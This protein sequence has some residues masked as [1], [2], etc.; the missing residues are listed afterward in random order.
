MCVHKDISDREIIFSFI[1]CNELKVKLCEARLGVAVSTN[2]SCLL[3]LLSSFSLRSGSQ[4]TCFQF[5]GVHI[6]IRLIYV[7]VCVIAVV[8]GKLMFL[9]DIMFVY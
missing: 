7:Y 4:Q 8:I 6:G 1:E 5:Y 9:D 3:L 2:I